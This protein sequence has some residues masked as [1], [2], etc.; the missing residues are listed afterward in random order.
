MHSCKYTKLLTAKISKWLRKSFFSKHKTFAY[1]Y[2]YPSCFDRNT[3]NRTLKKKTTEPRAHIATTVNKNKHDHYTLC[4][5]KWYQNT[6]H[7]KYDITLS[8]N[9]CSVTWQRYYKS[10]QDTCHH[11]WD[12][13]F[14]KSSQE[15]LSVQYGKI[16]S[17]IWIS[18]VHFSLTVATLRATRHC[19]QSNMRLLWMP[20]LLKRHHSLTRQHF[21]HLMSWIL[22]Q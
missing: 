6:N 15:N 9:Q 18:P 13:N 11:F 19:T 22:L 5:K 12:R 3:D 10:H 1:L 16:A 4:P 7:C 8:F 17:K 14:W 2:G 20:S 21:T